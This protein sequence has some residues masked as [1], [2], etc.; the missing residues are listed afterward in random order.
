MKKIIKYVGYLLALAIA[1]LLSYVTLALPDVGEAEDL[2]ID[3]APE[4]IER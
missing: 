4:R 3:Y 1:G 2:K